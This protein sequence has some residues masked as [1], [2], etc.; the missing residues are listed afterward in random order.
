[1]AADLGALLLGPALVL[2][3]HVL[4]AWRWA[5]LFPAGTLNR[6]FDLL[7]A[8]GVGYGVNLVAPLHLGELVR[9][10]LAT[11]RIDNARFAYVAATVAV[12]RATDLAVVAVI[13][14]AMGGASL[15][16]AMA[17]AAMAAL[18]FALVIRR[19]RRARGLVWRVASIFNDALK[20]GIVDFV[21]SF[22]EIM[23][24]PTLRRWRFALATAAMWAMYLLSYAALARFLG[25]PIASV[26][27][28]ML[29]APLQSFAQSLAAGGSFARQGAPLVVFV[30]VPIIII[31]GY[32]GIRDWLEGHRAIF[33]LKR[34]GMSGAD[35]PSAMRERFKALATY[36]Q[37]LAHLFDGGAGPLRDFER[38]A[39]GDAVVHKFFHGG[40]EAVTALVEVDGELR[41]R[42]FA[43]YA[44]AEKLAAQAD[45]LSDPTRAR[46]PLARV[47][48]RRG[49]EGGFRYD[50]PMVTPSSDF[51]DF[52]HTTPIE[53]SRA[54]LSDVLACM[55]TLHG[56]GAT[57][58]AAEI[59]AY[60]DVKARRNVE[61]IEDFAQRSLS[62]PRFTV[63]GAP[64]DINLWR[65]LSDPGWLRAQIRYDRVATIHGDLTIE[66]IIVAP[67]SPGGFY[68]ID[69]N[70]ENIFNSPLIDW[71]KLMQ[72]LHLGYENLNLG[73]NCRRDASSLVLSS[74]RT[75]NYAQLHAMLESE[76]VNRLGED[77]LREVY[78]HEIINYLRLTPYQIRR[79]P[80][81]GLSFFACVTMLVARYAERWG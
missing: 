39:I 61:I 18:G 27:Q 35:A 77:V 3:A 69:P 8:L 71:A 10:G 50:M 37:Y 15:A 21:W 66:N 60:L 2:I 54:L 16:A 44:A 56:D 73:G 62:W 34:Y 80:I 47:V 4:R 19:A 32:G 33:R 64:F 36:E 51:Y 43:V 41:I 30:S 59:D 78:F 48:E 75:H 42:K 72:S 1:M 14:A 25:A 40:S 52:V 68:L 65:R 49:G 6:R 20:M 11:R 58:E 13:F 79:Q 46:A 24:G 63:N 76:I 23:T 55:E 70:P 67:S 31:V 9:S 17:A 5:L 74:P 22:A 26:L 45:W 38:Q 28:S 53:R 81:R 57:A 29:G 12:E 7:L